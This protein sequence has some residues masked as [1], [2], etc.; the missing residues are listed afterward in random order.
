MREATWRFE[1]EIR[2]RSPP[3][4]F[5]KSAYELIRSNGLIGT[6]GDS[7]VNIDKEGSQ[8]KL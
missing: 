1:N 5:F 2:S 4:Y 6:G 3:H 7:E 8:L